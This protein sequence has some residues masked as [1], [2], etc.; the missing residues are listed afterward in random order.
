MRHLF[1]L[2]YSLFSLQAMTLEQSIAYALENNN[3][4]RQSNIA[5]DRSKAVRD[6][7]QAQNFGRLDLVGSYDHYNLPR[8]LAPLTPASLTAPGAAA[9]IPTTQ[10]MF[11]TGIAYNVVLF[12]GFAQQNAYSISDL[13]Y[14]TASIK[15]KL[16]RE[17]LIYNVRNLYLSLLSLEEQLAA[18][19]RYT[20]AQKSLL[21]HIK[22]EHELGS[23]AKIDV[24]KAQNSIEASHAQE[25]EMETNIAIIKATLSSLMGDKEFDKAEPMEIDIALAQEQ[26]TEDGEVTALAR[27]KASELAIK[28]SA[29]KVEQ[30]RSNYYP[31]IDFGAYYGQNF[32]PNDADT[33]YNNTAVLNR[34]EWNNQEIWQAGLHLKWNLLDFGATSSAAQVSKLDYM[35]ARLESEAVG[36]EL[37]KEITIAQNKIKHASAQYK[38]ASSQYALLS[39]TEKIEQ[40]RYENNALT[41]TDLLATRA[42]KTV[43]HAQLINAKYSYQ[44]ARYYLDYLFEKGDK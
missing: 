36:I 41:L 44:K 32:G 11:T 18:Q 19:Y 37:R 8:T 27:Y 31:T 9:A 26:L 35:R 42:D 3:A 15:Q 39:E 10:E 13:Q 7:K 43:A 28:A 12:D 1:L 17:E 38:S 23:K 20:E 16:G 30:S 29:R 14:Q 21:T 4:L 2:L 25:S 22:K 34:G 24:L 40:I 5:I 33:S 6:T